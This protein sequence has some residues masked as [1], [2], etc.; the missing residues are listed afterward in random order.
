VAYRAFLRH[1]APRTRWVGPSRPRSSPEWKPFAGSLSARSSAYAL[2]VL[3]AMYRWLMQQ[4]YVLANPFAGIKVRGATRTA[5]Q[6]AARVFSDGEWNLIRTVADGLE[7]SYGWEAAAAQRLRFV[8]DFAYGTG[9]RASELVGATL[10]QIETDEH[11]DHWLH[12]V[13][14]GSKAGKVALPPLAWAALN[15]YLAQRRLPTTSARWSP[16]TPLLGS[17]EQDSDAGI[18]AARLWNIVRRFF[19]TAA[20][21]IGESS[22]ATVEKLRRASPHWM[23]HYVPLRTMSR[24]PLTTSPSGELAEVHGT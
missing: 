12:V 9:L 14:K 7:W 2:T 15:R 6:A 13:G 5:S 8:L 16:N 24:S 11:G 4:H 10:G 3:G 1:P 22:P 20:E 18:T 21:V 23:R 17:L 19:D